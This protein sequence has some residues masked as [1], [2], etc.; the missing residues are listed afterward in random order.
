MQQAFEMIF[1]TFLSDV[2]QSEQVFN[3]QTEEVSIPGPH[4]MDFKHVK[5]N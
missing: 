1:S 5:K 2:V 3:T 4:G